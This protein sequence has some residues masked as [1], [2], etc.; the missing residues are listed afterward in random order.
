LIQWGWI[1]QK[2]LFLVDHWFKR[3]ST[4]VLVDSTRQ[5]I[6]A[7]INEKRLISNLSVGLK[8]WRAWFVDC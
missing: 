5:L 7:V 6:H 2:R 8:L 3:K 1:N 4:A